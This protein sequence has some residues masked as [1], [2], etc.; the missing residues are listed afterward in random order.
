[1]DHGAVGTPGETSTIAQR[2]EEA[3]CVT[4][5]SIGD[6]EVCVTGVTMDETT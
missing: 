4:T 2:T 1:L 3:T 5:L 6:C